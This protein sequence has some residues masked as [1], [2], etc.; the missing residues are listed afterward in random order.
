MKYQDSRIVNASL[1]PRL[2]GEG[3][4]VMFRA[5]SVGWKKYWWGTEAHVKNTW[6][7]RCRKQNGF[8]LSTV[9]IKVALPS[10][11]TLT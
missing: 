7:F 6:T 5:V 2:A 3:R 4:T 8:S 11:S 1:P 9:S 10:L